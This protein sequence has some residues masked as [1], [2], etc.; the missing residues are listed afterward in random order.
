MEQKDKYYIFLDIDGV[1]W[2]WNYLKQAQ[3]KTNRLLRADEVLNPDSVEALNKLI[4]V[5]DA[6]FD[7]RLVISS[8]WRNSTHKR[9]N[10]YM[11]YDYGL[12]YKKPLYHTRLRGEDDTLTTRGEEINDYLE[13]HG[14]DI[15]TGNYVVI[16][17]EMQSLRPFME[18]GRVI[19]TSMAQSLREI[20]VERF[21]KSRPELLSL[22]NTQE[23]M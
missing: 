9:N 15:E 4:D 11:L 7:T 13:R 17:D 8:S 14:M 19:E 18:M 10:N 2:D 6:G 3:A 23:G 22:I 5:I 21:V 12:K 1:L 20:D 16:D